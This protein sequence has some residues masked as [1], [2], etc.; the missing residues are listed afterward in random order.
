MSDQE[1]IDRIVDRLR[2]DHPDPAMRAKLYDEGGLLAY[3]EVLLGQ[4]NDEALAKR[5]A[6]GVRAAENGSVGPM[7]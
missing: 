3:V 5:V 6:D 4:D 1:H 7:R 2:P